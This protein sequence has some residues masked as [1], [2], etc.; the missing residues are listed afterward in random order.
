MMREAVEDFNKSGGDAVAGVSDLA[1]LLSSCPGSFFAY[2][3]DHPAELSH[4]LREV[5]NSLFWGDPKDEA[6]LNSYRADLIDFVERSS[7]GQAAEKRQ[8]IERLK[9]A[10]VRITE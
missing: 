7:T 2:M 3:H 8:I 5:Q 1:F 10:H 4:W 9:T 6:S